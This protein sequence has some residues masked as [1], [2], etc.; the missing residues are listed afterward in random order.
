MALV[1]AERVEVPLP[2]RVT[3]QHQ[4]QDNNPGSTQAGLGGQPAAQFMGKHENPG[5]QQEQHQQRTPPADAP[6]RGLCFRG[7]L[8]H[9]AL[10][11]VY[12]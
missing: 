9:C 5:G 3:P 8:G 10:H 1:L 7:L 11:L 6:A 2:V 4:R 12:R